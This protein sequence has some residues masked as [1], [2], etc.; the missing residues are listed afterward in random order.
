MEYRNISS[1]F[2]WL[3]DWDGDENLLSE[4]QLNAIDNAVKLIERDVPFDG[5]DIEI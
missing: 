5:C 2:W 1:F 4:E 3:G